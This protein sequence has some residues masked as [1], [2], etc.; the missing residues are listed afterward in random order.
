MDSF[1]EV[2]FPLTGYSLQTARTIFP[3]CGTVYKRYK[4]PYARFNYCVC[5]INYM[6]G[7]IKIGNKAFGR[8]VLC[9]KCV[10]TLLMR[11]G[12]RTK[13]EVNVVGFLDVILCEDIIILGVGIFYYF[14]GVKYMS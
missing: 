4:W 10:F 5:Y 2:V 9:S 3:E 1:S 8:V 13:G 14:T 12:G 7:K 6:S 11:V